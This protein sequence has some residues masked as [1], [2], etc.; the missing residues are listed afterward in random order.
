[1]MGTNDPGGFRVVFHDDCQTDQE[2]VLQPPAND[3]DDLDADLSLFDLE[4]I[5]PDWLPFGGNDR[6]TT[7]GIPMTF[8]LDPKLA[9]TLWDYRAAKIVGLFATTVD[10]YDWYMQLIR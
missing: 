3:Y 4:E 10:D 7:T 2:F 9:P 6:L 5:N 1:M 8:R